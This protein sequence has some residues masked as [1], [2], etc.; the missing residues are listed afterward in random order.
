MATAV[1]A[2]TSKALTSKALPTPRIEAETRS[3]EASRY[4]VETEADRQLRAEQD[5]HAAAHKLLMDKRCGLRDA[6]VAALVELFVEHQR[7]RRAAAGTQEP[8]D[9]EVLAHAEYLG[10]DR[11]RAL[12]LSA[13]PRPRQHERAAS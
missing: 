11:E 2:L 5:R 8:T 3:I 12:C 9:A 13:R 10:F 7:C 6:A 4:R 1:K